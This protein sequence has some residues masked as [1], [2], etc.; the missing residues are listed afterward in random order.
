MILADTD[1]LIDH[2]AGIQPSSATISACAS[3]DQLRTTAVNYFELM[4]GAE[5]MRGDII[6]VLLAAIPILPLDREAAE[7]AAEVRRKLER[8]GQS[9][10]MGDSLIA[11]IALA[12]GLPLLTRNRKHFERI[13]RLSLVQMKLGGES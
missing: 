8:Q 13:P 4:S 11:G 9:I 12:A 7:I 2:I 5:G 10:G 6:R 1:V 3:A